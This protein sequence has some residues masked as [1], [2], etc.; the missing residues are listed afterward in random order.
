MDV[1]KCWEP[2]GALFDAEGQRLKRCV[3]GWRGR[4]E[5]LSM[6]QIVHILDR[7]EDGGRRSRAVE[8]ARNE[9]IERG[10]AD[11]LRFAMERGEFEGVIGSL[12]A[13]MECNR[14]HA[15]WTVLD[16]EHSLLA[17]HCDFDGGSSSKYQIHRS[18]I[19]R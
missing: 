18:P 17:P 11:T 19:C 16:R 4:I 10:Y 5:S 6:E 1:V 7:G 13:A 8:M 3:D 12:E 14:I 15:V 2:I 9:L